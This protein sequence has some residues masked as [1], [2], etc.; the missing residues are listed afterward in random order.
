MSPSLVIISGLGMGSMT[1]LDL[2]GYK[3]CE[4]VAYFDINKVGV[5]TCVYCVPTTF[6]S[7]NFP[8]SAGYL[9]GNSGRL[10]NCC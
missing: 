7:W 2:N 1:V 6:I 10:R 3:I 8:I 4:N 9:G 5:R